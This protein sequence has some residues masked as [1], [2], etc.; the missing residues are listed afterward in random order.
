MP[1]SE[2]HWLTGHWAGKLALA[3]RPRGGDWLTDELENWKRSGVQ[4][5]LSLLTR[6]EEQE[7]GLAHEAKE[8][9]SIGLEFR[10]YPI[11]DRGVPKSDAELGRVSD[12]LNSSLRAGRN[13][14]LHCRRGIGRTGLVASC[15]LVQNGMSPGA[16]VDAVSSARGLAVPETVEQ[17]EWIE[18]YAPAFTK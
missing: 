4:T 18:R 8:A 10:S 5:V 1:S 16:A 7:L 14:L 2:F 15:L 6:G 17:R 13:V 3:A 11:E 12:T 9:K